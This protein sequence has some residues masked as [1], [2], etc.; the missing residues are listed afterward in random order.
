[1]WLG[2]QL[3]VYSP[4]ERWEESQDAHGHPEWSAHP[5]RSWNYGILAEGEL[6]MESWEVGRKAVTGDMFTLEGAPIWLSVRGAR[7]PGWRLRDDEAG[8]LPDSPVLD[9]QALERF[10]LYPYSAARIRI[11]ELPQIAGEPR[12]DL[13]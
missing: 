8:P 2:S 13:H 9:Y 1:V 5:R 10:K 6:G 11:A 3:M 12:A 7:V 4:G